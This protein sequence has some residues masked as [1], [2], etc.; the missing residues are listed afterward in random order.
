M[1]AMVNRSSKRSDGLNTMERIIGFAE[2]ELAEHGAVK[3]NLGR[4][5]ELAGV[6]KSSAY[7]HF[8]SRDGIIAAVETRHMLAELRQL[9]AAMRSFIETTSDAAEAIAVIDALTVAEGGEPSQQSRARRASAL[10]SARSNPALARML[11]DAQLEMVDYLAESLAIAQRRGLIDPTLPLVG[12]AHWF[13]SVSFGRI[14][15]DVT[16]DEN[17]NLEWSTVAMSALRSILRPSIN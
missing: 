8:G 14:L 6:S 4:V 2:Q 9:N 13:L 10:V 16:C 17:A 11:A 7:H 1:N 3:F 12:I 15:V 5:L